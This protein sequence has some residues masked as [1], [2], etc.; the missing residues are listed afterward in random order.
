MIKQKPRPA[1]R[2]FM[3]GQR[4]TVFWG[5]WVPPPN[6]APLIKGWGRLYALCETCLR[7]FAD[8]VGE[9]IG[10]EL[11]NGGIDHAQQTGPPGSGPTKGRS[12]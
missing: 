4:R 5:V 1:L 12:A 11:L 2:C 6:L 8:D 10:C 9:L 7:D 3:C